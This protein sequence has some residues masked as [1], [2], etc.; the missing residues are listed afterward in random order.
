MLPNC[1][2]TPQGKPTRRSKIRFLLHRIGISDDA[3]TDF[4][5]NDI[6]NVVQLFHTFNDETHGSSGRFTHSQLLSSRARVED[7]VSFLANII[8]GRAFQ[9]A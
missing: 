3:V 2:L 6:D 7:A 1:D 8:S 4:V 5:E 9:S